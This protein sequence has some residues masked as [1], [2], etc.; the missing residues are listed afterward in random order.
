MKPS[1]IPKRKPPRLPNSSAIS[2]SL[3]ATGVKTMLETEEGQETAGEGLEKMDDTAKHH[4]TT[5][6][7][8]DRA[9]PNFISA[10]PRERAMRARS[11][12]MSKILGMP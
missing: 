8:H 10:T 9:R 12:Q 4:S 3:L 1:R 11:N 5:L 7:K 6:A 2:S